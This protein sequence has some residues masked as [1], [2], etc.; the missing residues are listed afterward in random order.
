MF[1]FYIVKRYFARLKNEVSAEQTT[2]VL[3][4]IQVKNNS[5]CRAVWC[6][7]NVMS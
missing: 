5:L 1:K 3:D 6:D 2:I 4:I 7:N